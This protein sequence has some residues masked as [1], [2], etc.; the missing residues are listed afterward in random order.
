[1]DDTNDQP[2]QTNR[3]SSRS[4]FQKRKKGGIASRVVRDIDMSGGKF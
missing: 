1:M 4:E 3:T 2:A